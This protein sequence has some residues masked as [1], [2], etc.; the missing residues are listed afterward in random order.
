[1]KGQ[2]IVVLLKLLAL[3]GRSW[4]YQKLSQDLGMSSSEVHTAVKRCQ[5]AGLYNEHTRLPNR[6]ALKEFLV[7]GLRYVFPARPGPMV[8]GLPTSYAGPVL[9]G[10]IRF[11]HSELP[12]MPLLH[13]PARGTEISPLHHAAPDA[14]RSD[15]KLY[16]YLSLVD[17]LR[18]GRARERKLAIEALDK[19][20]AAE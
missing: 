15:P 5:N 8:Q 18:T 17:A 20:M 10:K 16:Q 9:A 4:T 2:D 7:H 13:G 6:S 11:D 19:M 1:M 3:E 12:V 14:A